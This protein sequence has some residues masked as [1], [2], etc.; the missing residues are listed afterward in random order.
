MANTI[1]SFF[2]RRWPDKDVSRHSRPAA[3]GHYLHKSPDLA[4]VYH[5]CVAIRATTGCGLTACSDVL[6]GLQ[7]GII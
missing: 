2:K 4:R 1:R 3:Y 6:S 7:I 5:A